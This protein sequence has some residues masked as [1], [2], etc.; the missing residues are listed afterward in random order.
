MERKS[1]NQESLT[2]SCFSSILADVLMVSVHRANARINDRKSILRAKIQN[3]LEFIEIL[4]EIMK[5]YQEERRHINC[6]IRKLL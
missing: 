1:A 4:D 6:Y 3:P 5:T 2:V